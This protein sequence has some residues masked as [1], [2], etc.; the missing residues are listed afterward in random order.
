M[1]Y[2]SWVAFFKFV[3]WRAWV[4][5]LSY[6]RQCWLFCVT[7]ITSGQTCTFLWAPPLFLPGVEIFTTCDGKFSWGPVN[8]WLQNWI[9]FQP[10][11]Q[12]INQLGKV[13]WL[14]IITGTDKILSNSL[15]LFKLGST[16]IT[17][18]RL[19]AF[20]EFVAVEHSKRNEFFF[21][22]VENFGGLGTVNGWQ[23]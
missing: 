4:L 16:Y 6:D 11:P 20:P 2:Q 12:S 5:V 15:K 19:S 22:E 8:L 1:V 14:L 9:S 17:H 7:L 13:P 23:S 3:K 21:R 10:L 18:S